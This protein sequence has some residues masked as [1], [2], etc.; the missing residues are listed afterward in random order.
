MASSIARLGTPH[1]FRRW[2]N[3]GI[4]PIARHQELDGDESDN[5]GVD[6]GEQQTS[7]DDANDGS[8]N[9]W[10]NAGLSARRQRTFGPCNGAY[11]SRTSHAGARRIHPAMHGSKPGVRIASPSSAVKMQTSIITQTSA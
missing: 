11:R 9:M 4:S 10:P 8:A 7:K 1:L 3:P 2:K 5:R 6:G